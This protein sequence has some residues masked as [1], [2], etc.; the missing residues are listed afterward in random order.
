MGVELTVGGTDVELRRQEGIV[1]WGGTVCRVPLIRT[2]RRVGDALI[3]LVYP[4]S[5]ATADADIWVPADRN[6]VAIADPCDHR[7]TVAPPAGD[8][9][10]PE[11][12]FLHDRIL[13]LEQRVVTKATTGELYCID[14]TD[15]TIRDAWAP[16][17]F[18]VGGTRH[19]F[20]QDV[21]FAHSHADSTAV[22]TFDDTPRRASDDATVYGFDADGT[23]LWHV[24]LDHEGWYNWV[25]DGYVYCRLSDRQPT[26]KIDIRTGDCEID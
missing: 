2:Y 23:Q 15:G 8:G 3:L 14:G 26:Y 6:L 1:D 11:R 21:Q 17:E 13:G 19:S 22:V 10:D 20:E 24:E 12:G 9:V 5:D 25:E 4:D 16:D 7:W 18:V